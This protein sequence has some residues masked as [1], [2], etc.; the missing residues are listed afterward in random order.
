MKIKI[1]YFKVLLW[2]KKKKPI[3]APLK[4]LSF[5]NLKEAKHPWWEFEYALDR[6]K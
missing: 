1:S 5:T 4:F 3:A 2:T 6:I